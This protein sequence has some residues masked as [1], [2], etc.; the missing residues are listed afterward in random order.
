MIH[1]KI[2]QKI[3]GISA[4]LFLEAQELEW[5]VEAAKKL[6]SSS[7]LYFSL[8]IKARDAREKYNHYVK[9]RQSI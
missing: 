9:W 8:A 2:Q 7:E 3:E 5:Q 1:T 4:T 6:N